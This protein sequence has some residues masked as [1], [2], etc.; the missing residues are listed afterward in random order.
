MAPR[1]A[2]KVYASLVFDVKRS[3]RFDTGLSSVQVCEEHLI[4]T[5]ADDSKISSPIRA[6]DR[7]Y[8]VDLLKT[9]FEESGLARHAPYP[10]VPLHDDPPLLSVRVEE[11]SRGT[12]ISGA[13]VT[14]DVNPSI[15]RLNADNRVV[16]AVFRHVLTEFP[17]VIQ[18]RLGRFK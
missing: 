10:V 3:S 15:Y 7:Q 16:W 18:R 14:C 11:R 6:K 8:F 1:V 17:I 2:G 12:L 5:R 9:E 13:D 4:V